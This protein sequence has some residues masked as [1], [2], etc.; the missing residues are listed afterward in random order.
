MAVTTEQIEALEK[1]FLSTPI[2]EKLRIN[3]AEVQNNVPGFINDKINLLRSGVLADNIAETFYD[4]LVVIQ[5]KL[6]S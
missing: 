5:H 2:P 6:S 3:A 4:H 1:F